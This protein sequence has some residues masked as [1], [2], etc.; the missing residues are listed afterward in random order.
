M[1]SLNAVSARHSSR[2]GLDSM[3]EC[4]TMLR[5]LAPSMV[6][7]LRIGRASV[8]S[9]FTLATAAGTRREQDAERQQD[10]D[11]RNRTARL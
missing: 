1:S 10:E 3:T 2:S 4:G 9:R 7:S 5:R 6:P 8:A 11:E